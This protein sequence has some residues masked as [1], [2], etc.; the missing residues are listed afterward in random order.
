M[1]FYVG[2]VVTFTSLTCG[3]ERERLDKATLNTLRRTL[4]P[5]SHSTFPKTSYKSLTDCM[6]YTS[7]HTFISSTKRIII[8]GTFTNSYK[9]RFN[10]RCLRRFLNRFDK[11]IMNRFIGRNMDTIRNRFTGR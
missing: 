8:N 7:I 10:G 11:R 5:H 9:N 3:T 1:Y 2:V 6:I 4:T